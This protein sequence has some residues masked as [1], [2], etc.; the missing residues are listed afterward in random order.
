MAI[1][2]AFNLEIQQYDAV[3][4]FI[5]ADVDEEIYCYCPEGFKEPGMTWK[6][7]KALYGLKQSPLL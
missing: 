4:A 3:N 1:S 5:N 7:R 6:L 2:A